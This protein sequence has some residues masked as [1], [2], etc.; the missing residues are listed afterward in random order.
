MIA[1]DNRVQ[2]SNWFINARRRNLPQLNKQAAAESALR[3][4]HDK[5]AKGSKG[6]ARSAR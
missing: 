3:E 6:P 1:A 5:D 2:I 4:L